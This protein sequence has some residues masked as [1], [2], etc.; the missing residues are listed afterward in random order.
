MAPETGF[1]F[2][3]KPVRA[4]SDASYAMGAEGIVVSVTM[5]EFPLVP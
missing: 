2:A 1:Q 4:T 3:L 5:F